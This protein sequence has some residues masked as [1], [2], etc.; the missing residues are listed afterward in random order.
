[1]AKRG[2]IGIADAIAGAMKAREGGDAASALDAAKAKLGT[3]FT[4]P[5]SV[6]P[7]QPS[8]IGILKSSSDT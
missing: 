4:G 8:L 7:A 3:S 5:L 6:L 1:M 2:G